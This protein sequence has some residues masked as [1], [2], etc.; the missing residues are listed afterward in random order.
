MADLD[1]RG[2]GVIVSFERTN[3]LQQLHLVHRIEEVHAQAFWSA[4]GHAGDFGNAERRS[5]RCEDCAR[6]ANLVE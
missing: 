4:V 6:T 3:N 2:Q 5:I 1:R